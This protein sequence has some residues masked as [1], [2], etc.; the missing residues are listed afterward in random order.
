MTLKRITSDDIVIEASGSLTLTGTDVAIDATTLAVGTSQ[1]E[2]IYGG[3]AG[4]MSG[5]SALTFDYNTNTFSVN[6]T[7]IT[8]SQINLGTLRFNG[9]T[10][11][12]STTS[13][14]ANLTINPNGTGATVIEGSLIVNGN[15][16]ASAG[17][18]MD[19]S[20]ANL[21]QI[22]LDSGSPP[23]TDDSKDRGILFN[24]HNGSTAK[25]GFIGYDRSASAIVFLTDATYA[26]DLITNAGTITNLADIKANNATFYTVNVNSDLVVSGNLTVSGTTTTVNTT[27]LQVVDP[28]VSIGRGVDNAPLTVDDSKDR[29]VSMYWYNGST[30]KVAFAGF[31]R[32]TQRFVY[33]PDATITGEVVSG[34]V[35]TIEA[36]LQ[37]NADTATS[38]S[39]ITISTTDGNTSDTTMYPVLVGANSTGSQ[40]PH[41]DGSGL[42][43]NASTNALTATTF[44]GALSGNATTATSATS[45]TTATTA[46]NINISTTDGNTSDTTM[47][48]VLVGDN[49]TGSQ[50]PHTDISG[51]TYDASTNNLTATTFTGALSGNAT[52]A[53]T[54]TTATNANNINISTTDGNTSD[55]TMYV[56]LVGANTTGNQA[57]HTDIAG[58]SYNASTNVLSTTASQAQYADLAER[59]EADMAYEVGTVLIFGGDK[60]VTRST[61]AFDRRVA[62]VVS[63][64]PA[65]LMNSQAGSDSTHPAIALQGRVP[66]MVVGN[67]FK[68]DLL[69]TS[70]I[71]GVAQSAGE[72]D[73]RPG[74]VIGKALENYTAN[75]VGVI[76]VVVG[77]L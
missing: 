12:L 50:A 15:I 21:F 20:D 72:L 61:Q 77:R 7:T 59:Y 37:G 31:D 2:V 41:I 51:L 24:W 54:A 76:E 65:Y 45:A 63:A 17:F 28:V 55:T 1:Y 48:V 16:V 68:G 53:T 47:Y 8:S 70:G 11:T 26:S 6:G 25:T 10:N 14:N 36:N 52:T 22:G 4:S 29:G 74:S 9:S 5:S 49:T 43:Y 40:A 71:A 58:I 73:P 42:S 64:T 69:V 35:G 23:T 39:N 27:S 3:A 75:G 33:I 62:G 18:S 46:T 60:E 57:P 44:I 19:S 56:V 38:V 13:T 32:S 30:E 67:V 66:C 34:T